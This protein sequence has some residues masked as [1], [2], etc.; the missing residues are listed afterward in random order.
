MLT[1]PQY[2]SLPFFYSD[3]PAVLMTAH[4]G[5][6]FP[7]S[8][9][10]RCGHVTKFWPI[11]WKWNGCL[12][13][14]TAFKEKQDALSCPFSFSY[15]LQSGRDGGSWSIHLISQ[16]GS[17]VLRKAEQIGGNWVSNIKELHT[18]SGKPMLRLLHQE[19]ELPFLCLFFTAASTVS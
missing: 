11:L 1:V 9:A 17:Y 13:L 6:H 3:V 18:S 19:N 10:V 14:Q 8:L 5:L 2:Y 16:D 12:E 4:L 15:Q 7:A